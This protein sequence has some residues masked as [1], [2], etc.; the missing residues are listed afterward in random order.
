MSLDPTGDA[1]LCQNRGGHL[2]H[3][4]QNDRVPRPHA[5]QWRAA[6]QTAEAAES[7]DVEPHPGKHAG[8]FPESLGGQG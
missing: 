6:C 7:V 4:G 1:D 8:A 5:Q 2:G 3:V